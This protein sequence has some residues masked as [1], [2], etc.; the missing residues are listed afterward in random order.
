MVGPRAHRPEFIP[1]LMAQI[2][3]Y[4]QRHAMRP[5]IFGWSQ[6]NCEYRRVPDAREAL[7]YDLYYIKHASPALDANIILHSLMELPFGG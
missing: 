6:L 1:I 7:E 4:G 2:P 3:Y 5:G